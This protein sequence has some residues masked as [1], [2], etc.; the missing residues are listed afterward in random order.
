MNLLG[1]PEPPHHGA[2]M[3]EDIRILMEEKPTKDELINQGSKDGKTNKHQNK[4]IRIYNR[5]ICYKSENPYWQTEGIR[6]I[7]KDFE[8]DLKSL[9]RKW[10]IMEKRKNQFVK[11]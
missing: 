8:I 7:L 1:Y 2:C 4:N 10:N 3:A 9:K 5:K 6:A 11:E